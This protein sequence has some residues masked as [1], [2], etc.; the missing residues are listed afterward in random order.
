MNIKTNGLKALILLGIMS[1]CHSSSIGQD[2]EFSQPFSSSLR[3]NPALMGASNGLDVGVAYRTRYTGVEDGYVTQRF[4]AHYPVLMES[5]GGKLD[6]GLSVIRDQAA[7]FETLDGMLSVNYDINLSKDHHFSVALYGGYIQNKLNTDDLTY[8][9]QYMNGSFDRTLPT[10]EAV[11]NEQATSIDAGFGML[12]YYNPEKKDGES[13][14]NAFAGVS[15]F[16]M[17]APN[18]SFIEGDGSRPQKFTSMAGVKWMTKGK[19]TFTP[20][21]RLTTQNGI[22]RI[23]TGMYADY[24]MNDNITFTLGAWNKGNSAF[25]ALLGVRYDGFQ[26][27][28]SYDTAPSRLANKISGLNTM[29]LSLSY[30][31]SQSDDRGPSPFRS[32]Y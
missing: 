29:E 6:V 22:E 21:I 16:H 20:N 1:F 30:Y 18:E 11:V 15:G 12:W 26:V 19:M 13:Q 5:K 4:N 27:G 24:N 31:M 7:A 32:L 25:S 2:V 3:L 10:G 14:I 17:N 23:A 9:S 28:A 8:D